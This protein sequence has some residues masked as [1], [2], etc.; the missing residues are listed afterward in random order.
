MASAWI[1]HVKK[2]ASEKGISY[3]EALKVAKESYKK[4][5]KDE[6]VVKEKKEKVEKMPKEKVVKEKKEMPK[7]KMPRKKKL[8]SAVVDK[9]MYEKK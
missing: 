1:E 2:V 8:A 6:K 3:T 9:K 5:E 7:E 4:P